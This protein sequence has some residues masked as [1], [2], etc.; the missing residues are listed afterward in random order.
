MIMANDALFEK[1][2][3][4]NESSNQIVAGEDQEVGNEQCLRQP[5]SSTP[6]AN[7]ANLTRWVSLREFILHEFPT[8]PLGLFYKMRRWRFNKCW[9]TWGIFIKGFLWTTSQCLQL[10]SCAPWRTQASPLQWELMLYVKA[11][12]KMIGLAFRCTS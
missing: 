2:L 9:A 1:L 10:L 5:S 4:G 7:L 6:L 3:T 12:G 8:K 11:W